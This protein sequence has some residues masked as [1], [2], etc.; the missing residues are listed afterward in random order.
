MPRRTM[1]LLVISILTLMSLASCAVIAQPGPQLRTGLRSS[2]YGISPFPQPQWWLDATGDMADDFAG[3]EPAAIWIVGVIGMPDYCWL[4][5]PVPEGEEKPP[6]VVDNYADANAP[7][8]EQFDEEGVKVWLQVEPGA[9]DV[10]TLIDLLLERYAD[11]PSVVGVGVDVEWYLNREYK[12]GKAV[13]DAEAEAWV[14]QIRSYDPKLRLFLKHWLPEKLPPTYRDGVTFISDSQGFDNFE[15]M[16]GEFNAWGEHFAPH[17]VG[18]QYG[19]ESDQA[20]WD[21]FENPPAAIGQR[22]QEDVPNLT[23]L[24]WVDFTAREIWPEE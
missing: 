17:P 12:W 14:E 21:D 20:W 24:Y 4:N 3:A 16:L 7:Y 9:A 2:S 8:L 1:I 10:S 18:F 22:L 15:H 5:F 11:H 23:D 13:T 19:Y 6:K